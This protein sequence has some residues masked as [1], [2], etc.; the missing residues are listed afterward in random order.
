[1]TRASF[2]KLARVDED[3]VAE[4][5]YDYANAKDGVQETSG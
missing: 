1:M 2:R 3:E 4:R 5:F